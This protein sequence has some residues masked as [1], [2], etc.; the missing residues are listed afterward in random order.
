MPGAPPSAEILAGLG[1]TSTFS[2]SPTLSNSPNLGS[3]PPSTEPGLL[4]GSAH[5]SLELPAPP[6]SLWAPEPVPRRAL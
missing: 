4:G 1:S 5:S 3:S 6:A 2:N